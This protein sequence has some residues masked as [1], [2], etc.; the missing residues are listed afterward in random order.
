MT[1]GWAGNGKRTFQ[2]SV[3]CVVLENC[4][5]RR[6]TLLEDCCRCELEMPIHQLPGG[7]ANWPVSKKCRMHDVTWRP[8]AVSSEEPSNCGEPWGISISRYCW[9]FRAPG[10]GVKRGHWGPQRTEFRKQ[11]SN[12]GSYFILF[13]AGLGID[14][15]VLKVDVLT[16]SNLCEYEFHYCCKPDGLMVHTHVGNRFCTVGPSKAY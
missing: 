12:S 7:G 8:P 6:R 15:T 4:G 16:W 10:V 11:A 14:Y 9:D 1:G 5:N 2:S 3:S 13:H